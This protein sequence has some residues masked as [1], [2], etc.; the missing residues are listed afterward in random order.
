MRRRLAVLKTGFEDVFKCL[1]V[2]GIDA[3]VALCSVEQ[4]LALRS[5]GG[6]DGSLL[7]LQLCLK[8]GYLGFERG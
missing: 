4:R 1:A 8:V 7:L 3:A 6:L 5:F 2:C